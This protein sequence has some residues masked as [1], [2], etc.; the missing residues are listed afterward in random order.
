LA[1][2]KRWAPMKRDD[3]TK[4]R[5]GNAL[6]EWSKANGGSTESKTIRKTL[7]EKIKKACGLIN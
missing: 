4:T 6:S 2:M 5:L 7:S 1:E 3:R